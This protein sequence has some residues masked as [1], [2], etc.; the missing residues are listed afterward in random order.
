[1]LK[2]LNDLETEDGTRS[3]NPMPIRFDVCPIE[4]RY[5]D[6]WPKLLMRKNEEKFTT[7]RG[8]STKMRAFLENTITQE[9]RILLPHSIR[10]VHGI[11]YEERFNNGESRTS[12]LIGFAE[13]DDIQEIHASQVQDSVI[14]SDTFPEFTQDNFMRLMKYYCDGLQ[15]PVLMHLTMRWTE[16]Y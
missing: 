11:T 6:I 7:F 16:V 8:Y 4:P 9:R 3:I 5:G 14:K 12:W 13:V 10:G 1:M 15:D 2:S